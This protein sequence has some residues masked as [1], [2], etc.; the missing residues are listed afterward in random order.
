[1]RP[2]SG[3]TVSGALGGRSSVGI[4]AGERT[5]EASL[6]RHSDAWRWQHLR[7]SGATG[8]R[9]LGSR[10]RHRFR[11]CRRIVKSGGRP[12]LSFSQQSRHDIAGCSYG[13][14]VPLADL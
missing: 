11:R 9:R 7:G 10:L 12:R 4:D 2:R 14:G 13:S 3:Q 1:M 5:H 8:R 6:T